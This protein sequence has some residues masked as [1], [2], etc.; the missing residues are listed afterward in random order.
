MR[1]TTC[2]RPA[3]MLRD[4]VVSV[5]MLLIITGIMLPGCN[6]RAEELGRLRAATNNN[7]RQM[8]VAVHT[9]V[10]DY[11][12]L[13]PSGTNVNTMGGPNPRGAYGSKSGS[14]YMHLLP[15]VEQLP[16]YNTG[17][18]G[19]VPTYHAALDPSDMGQPTGTSFPFNALVFNQGGNVVGRNLSSGMPDGTSNV[20]MFS[21][22]AVQSNELRDA[23]APTPE[24]CMISDVDLPQFR[25]WFPGKARVKLFQAFEV[26]GIAVCM[27][28][29]NLRQ[30]SPNVSASSWKAA[31]IPNDAT[32]PGPDF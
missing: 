7:L 12:R 19:Y 13:P 5:V 1:L 3:Y 21:T 10:G 8:A 28:D 29:A 31:I 20:I 26:A 11:K 14:L 25:D 2:R 4:L 27:G 16:M 23:F 9:A 24:N 32:N 30:V 18:F 17:N 6:N 22:G 15:Y